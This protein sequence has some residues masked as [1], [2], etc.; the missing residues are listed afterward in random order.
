MMDS[1]MVKNKVPR[2]ELIVRKING[3]GNC[4][5]KFSHLNIYYS[6]SVKIRVDPQK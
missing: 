3:V 2:I 6:V 4:R 5:Q 1:D